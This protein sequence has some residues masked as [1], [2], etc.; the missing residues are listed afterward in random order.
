M[1]Q[2]GMT[3]VALRDIRGGGDTFALAY[4][5]GDL[6][7]ESAVEPNGVLVLGEDVAA[8]EGARLERPANNASQAAWVAYALSTGADENEVHDMSRSA[9]IKAYG[10]E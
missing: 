9:L 7:H 8:R 1:E 2:P 5:E 6:V 4:R 3:F 10:G